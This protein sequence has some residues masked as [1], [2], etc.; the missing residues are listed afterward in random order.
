M[1]RSSG[2]V[3][4]AASALQL[5]PTKDCA[6]GN[7]F[8]GWQVGLVDMVVSQLSAEYHVLSYVSVSVPTPEPSQTCLSVVG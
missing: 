2:E 8:M 3:R 1:L 5:R 6:W 4:V 7:A